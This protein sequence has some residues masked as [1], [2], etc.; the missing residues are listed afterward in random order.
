MRRGRAAGILA[1]ALPWGALAAVCV[2]V[3]AHAQDS[4]A[5]K[6]RM[7]SVTT[8]R[9]LY[10]LQRAGQGVWVVRGDTGKGAEGRPNAGFIAT[11]EGVIAVGGLASPAQ[12]RAVIRTI[13]TRSQAPLRYLVLYAHHPDMSFGA[14]EFKRAGAQ[15]VSHPNSRVLAA[16]GGPDAEMADWHSV[17][18]LQE[19][20]GFEFANA[21]DHPVTGWDTLRLGGREVVVFHPG[22]AHSLGDLMVWVPSDR[23]LFAG[24]ILVE[25]GITMVVDGNSKILL[26]TLDLIDSLKPRVVVPGH[27][28]IPTDPTELTR[29]TRQYIT[30]LRDSMQ[31]EVARGRS[32]RRAIE[33]FPPPDERRPVTRNSRIRRNAARVYQ[34][35]ERAALGLDE[36]A[37]S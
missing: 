14:I 16:E 30:T 24:D 21:P 10:P 6:P 35:M 27:G 26:R 31:A 11:R 19:L 7:F 23:V 32:Q 1:R 37:G 3:P 2:A 15:V 28:R 13:R 18:G 17:V 33:A 34:E 5:P 12:A 20:V 4:A 8:E 9:T 36:E 29:L 22:Q 25:D